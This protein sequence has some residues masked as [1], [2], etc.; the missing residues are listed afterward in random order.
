MQYA[1]ISIGTHPVWV[2]WIPPPPYL[3]KSCPLQGNEYLCP[4]CRIHISTDVVDNLYDADVTQIF[5]EPVSLQVA[6]TYYEII[7]NPMD[8]STMYQKA[9]SGIYKSLQSLRDDFELMCLNAI[10]FNK[11]SV[12]GSIGC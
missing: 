3:L 4:K 10:T 6:K 5:G 7:R 1:A 9:N 11:V 12:T 8:L 2:C